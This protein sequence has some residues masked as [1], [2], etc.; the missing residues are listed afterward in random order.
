[1]PEPPRVS[2]P[3]HSV[4]DA[5]GLR[6]VPEPLTGGQGRSVR[7]GGAV[8]KPAEGVEGESEWAASVLERLP[9]GA[10]FRVPRP[11]RSADGDAVVDGWTAAEFLDG[12]TGP[13]RQ[14][15]GV[16]AA[17]RALHA[18]LREEPRPEFLDRRTHPWAVA[19]RVAW[20]EREAGVVEELAEPFALLLSRWRPV[21]A[22]AQLVHGDLAGNVLF[23]P[24]REPAVI[25]FTP[26]WRPPLYAEAVVIVDG[27]LWYDLPPDLLAVGADD[28]RWRQMLIRA[29][30]F[31]LVALSG[32][33]GPSWRAGE[34]EATR[35]LAVAEVVERG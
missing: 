25:D 2:L 33:A 28:P 7:V 4:L 34:K 6:G 21:E 8:L 22:V 16:L 18:A 13:Q 9:R 19:D 30:I 14:W 20:G 1:M 5:F 35:F 11:L 10:G 27:L 17:G 32:L 23:A 26:Y 3:P 24:G 29:L 31:R 15:S 12:R